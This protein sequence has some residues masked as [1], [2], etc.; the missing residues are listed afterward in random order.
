MSQKP[1]KMAF[2]KHDL[3]S[4]N[5][6]KTNDVIDALSLVR[7]IGETAYTIYS[8]LGITAAVYVPVTKHYNRYGNSVLASVYTICRNLL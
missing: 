5:G 1:S 6:L 7:R 8:M 3:A 4:A 2:Y